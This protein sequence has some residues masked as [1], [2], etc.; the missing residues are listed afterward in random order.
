MDKATD[1][2]VTAGKEEHAGFPTTGIAGSQKC[3][4]IGTVNKEES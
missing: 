2:E 1:R 4:A 3:P